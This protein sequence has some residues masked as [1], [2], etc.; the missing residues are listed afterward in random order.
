MPRDLIPRN[1]TPIF[2]WDVY[3]RRREIRLPRR[4]SFL[5]VGNFIKKRTTTLL[6]KCPVLCLH[7]RSRQLLPS[8]FSHSL[9]RLQAL[10]KPGASVS[11]KGR[12][13]RARIESAVAGLGRCGGERLGVIEATLYALGANSERGGGAAAEITL[14]TRR[15]S[16]TIRAESECVLS[17]ARKSGG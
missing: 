7:C 12:C 8:N 11:P 1:P 3:T 17:R 5:N 15:G 13:A 16:K 10:S 14:S 4:R 9:P 6:P 2:A